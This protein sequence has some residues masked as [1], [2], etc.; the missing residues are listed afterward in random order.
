MNLDNVTNNAREAF[1]D[2]TLGGVALPY[3]HASFP[4]AA[5]GG[6]A[7]PYDH[8]SF[9]NANGFEGASSTA[10]PDVDK[11]SAASSAFHA[12]A[13]LFTV[14][15]NIFRPPNGQEYAQSQLAFPYMNNFGYD[16]TSQFITFF[17]SPPKLKN[18]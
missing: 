6:V 4:N 15:D 7:T 3:S 14:N 2:A 17:M 16:A 18:I 13:S 11:F 5:F 12:S 10:N 1:G 8:T 9:P